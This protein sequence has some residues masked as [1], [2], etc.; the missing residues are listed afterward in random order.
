[1]RILL[2]PATTS[3]LQY[4]LENL[5]EIDR[6]EIAATAWDESRIAET[7]APR[8]M[9]GA[10]MTLV[11]KGELPITACGLVPLCPGVAVAFAFSTPQYRHAIVPVT[12]F[13]RTVGLSFALKAGFHRIEFRA[14]AT[15]PDVE[16]W[17][18]LLGAQRESTLDCFGKNGE[19]FVM[20]RWLRHEHAQRRFSETDRPVAARY[21]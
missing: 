14:L 21:N 6:A 5:R 3:S 4:I 15:R 11:A 20:Y 8:I 13:I 16:R 17:V 18:G 2:E 10:V 12:R 7:L 19:D 1:M 9:A